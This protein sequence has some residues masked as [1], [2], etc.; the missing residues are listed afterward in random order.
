MAS[1]AVCQSPQRQQHDG[2][3]QT[4]FQLKELFSEPSMIYS[5]ALFLSMRAL[6]LHASKRVC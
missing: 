2:T 6:E 1:M 3:V 4:A 5:L